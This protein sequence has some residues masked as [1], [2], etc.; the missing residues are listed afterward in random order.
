LF[1]A[2]FSPNPYSIKRRIKTRVCQSVD[3]IFVNHRPHTPLK[4]GLWPDLFDSNGVNYCVLQPTIGCR[5]ALAL[6][7]I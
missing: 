4:E 7:Q 6:K 5:D 2:E 1:K 3:S